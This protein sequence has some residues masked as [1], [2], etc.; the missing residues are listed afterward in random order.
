MCRLIGRMLQTTK[1][2]SASFSS[3]LK[4]RMSNQVSTL[5]AQPPAHLSYSVAAWITTGICSTLSSTRPWIL[6]QFRMRELL[7]IA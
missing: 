3:P 6:Y 5:S 7:V 2:C 4:F 1:I